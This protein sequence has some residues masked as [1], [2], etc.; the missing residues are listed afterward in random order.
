MNASKLVNFFSLEQKDNSIKNTKISPNIY[1]YH[2]L[3]SIIAIIFHT[4]IGNKDNK[5]K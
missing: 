2:C 3:V 1:H 5:I 4:L